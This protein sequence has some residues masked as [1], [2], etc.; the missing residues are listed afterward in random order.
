M[1]F[2]TVSAAHG[3]LQEQRYFFLYEQSQITCTFQDVFSKHLNSLL[4][5]LLMCFQMLF[6]RLAVPANE[7]QLL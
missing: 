6:A 5:H 7:L 1:V 2:G 4:L 3:A